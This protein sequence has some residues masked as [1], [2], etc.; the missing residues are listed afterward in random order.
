MPLNFDNLCNMSTRLRKG[1]RNQQA[2]IKTESSDLSPVA[3]KQENN[4]T[5]TSDN[6]NTSPK[7]GKCYYKN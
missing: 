1:R 2:A 5:T 4:N 6:E 7:N 3:I